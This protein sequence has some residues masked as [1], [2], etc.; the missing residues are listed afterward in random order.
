M[1]NNNFE[2]KKFHQSR[3]IFAIIDGTLYI[4]PA[5]VNSSHFEWLESEKL[6]ESGGDKQLNNITRGF[7]DD[8]SLYFY[9]GDFVV[10][11][12]AEADIFE[13]LNDLV[14][15]LN[16]NTKIHLYGGFIKGKIGEKW[17]P[18]KDYGPIKD[19]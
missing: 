15:K 1:K 13:H 6:L 18:V 8:V 11:P 19:I 7:V 12:K 9:E 17:L 14:N 2:E 4:A 16:I 5:D 3:R 10:T